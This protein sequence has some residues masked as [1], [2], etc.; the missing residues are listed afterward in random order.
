MEKQT[1]KKRTFVMKILWITSVYP[2]CMKP[3]EGVFH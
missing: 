3:G 2:S 1:T